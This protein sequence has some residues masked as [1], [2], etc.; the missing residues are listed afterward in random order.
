MEEGCL[1]DSSG[2]RVNFKN[3]IVVMTCNVGARIKGEGLG[4]CSGGREME[5]NQA[6][7]QA[8]TPEFL[9]RLDGLIAFSPLEDSAMEAIAGKYLRQLQERVELLG[10]QLLI[11]EDLA[12]RLGKRCRGRDGARNLRRLVQSEVEGPLAAF[13]LRFGRKPPRLRLCMEGE[14]IHFLV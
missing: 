9:G 10:T 5:L 2:H 3:T 11:P 6:V 8:F 1:T 4:F 12:A 7:R 14:R 13:L